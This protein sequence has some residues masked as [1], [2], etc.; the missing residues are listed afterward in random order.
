M[1]GLPH[2]TFHQGL[3][4]Q[5]AWYKEEG[6]S[7]TF[8]KFNMRYNVE[9]SLSTVGY[10]EE[11]PW[12]RPSSYIQALAANGDF[13][14]LL[15]GMSLKE[16]APTLRTFWERYQQI[17]PDFE[18]FKTTV[19]NVDFSKYIPFFAHADEGTGYK[20]RGSLSLH[21]NRPL[22]LAAGAP[23]MYRPF[24]WKWFEHFGFYIY[25]I[26]TYMHM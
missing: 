23:Q 21:F 8:A 19:G 6:V 15:G 10:L 25:Y 4:A 3:A 2:L 14:K 26:Y 20:K 13:S 5:P 11:F 22:V 7:A 1:C 24:G 12:I 18:L 16:A 9:I 17:H